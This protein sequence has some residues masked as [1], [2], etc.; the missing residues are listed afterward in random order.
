MGAIAA[1]AA[2]LTWAFASLLF[3]RHGRSAGGL[4]LNLIKCVIAAALMFPTLLLLEGRI[5]PSTMDAA[6]VRWLGLSGLVGLSVGDTFW[7]GCLLRLGARRALLLFTLAPPMTALLAHVVL[8]EP[9]T[10]MM[11]VGMAI[12]LAGVAWVIRER[13]TVGA[14]ASKGVDG[15]GV[16]LGCA[17]AVCQAIGS[18]LTKY[19][20]TGESALAVSLVR[21]SVGA[22]GLVV[23]VGLFGRLRAAAKPFRD[24]RTATALV[25]ATILGTYLGIWLMNAGFLATYVG[26]AATL[27]A[28]S[29]IFALPLVALAG[30]RVSARATVGAFIAV[31]GVAVLFLFGAG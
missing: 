28:T 12:T 6:T 9:F 3:E 18:V 10:P 17:A 13:D 29:P 30:E 14:V 22:L 4:T 8:G 26:V 24:R 25:G 16:A 15:V 27:N 1:L 20:G 31:A 2:A 11:C 23:V 19:A 7:F 21:L 5:W